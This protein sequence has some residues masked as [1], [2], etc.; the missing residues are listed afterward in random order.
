M[1]KAHGNCVSLVN[2]THI[3]VSK[4]LSWNILLVKR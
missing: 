1:L 4:I 2:L 3:L